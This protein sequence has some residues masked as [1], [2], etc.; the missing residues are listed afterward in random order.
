MPIIG[1]V[2]EYRELDRINKNPR[3]SR[4]QGIEV[5]WTEIVRIDK[6]PLVDRVSLCVDQP[7]RSVGIGLLRKQCCKRHCQHQYEGKIEGLK[8]DHVQADFIRSAVESYK[9]LINTF[10]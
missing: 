9:Y 10:R 2:I 5:G 4:F 7:R 6:N 1:Q 8:V 3:V